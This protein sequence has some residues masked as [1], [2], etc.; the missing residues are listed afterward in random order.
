VGLLARHLLNIE[1]TGQKLQAREY[2]LSVL[3]K[4]YDFPTDANAPAGQVIEHVDVRELRLQPIEDVAQRLTLESIGAGGRTIWDMADTHIGKP[5]VREAG[6]VITRARL[7]IRFA[8]HGKSRRNKSLNLTIT[9]PHGCNLKSLTVGERLV[10]EKYLREW[11]ILKGGP[12]T[13]AAHR[14]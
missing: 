10:G 2:D 8:R 14:T 5:E 6:W 1:F 11:G 12:V 13:D 3:M 7:A 4:P 9:I